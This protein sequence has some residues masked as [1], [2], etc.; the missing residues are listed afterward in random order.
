MNSL[1]YCTLWL[2]AVAVSLLTGCGPQ[3]GASAQVAI[4]DL[5]IV[6]RETGQDVVIRQRA[7]EGINE[8]TNQLQQL[9]ASL[10][11][12][13]ADEREKA[14]AAPSAEDAARLQQLT[15]QAR[16]QVGQAQQQAQQQANDLEAELIEDFRQ[17]LLPLAKQIAAE[18]GLSLILSK[19]VF[20]FW[21]DEAVD[22]TDAVV[23]AWQAQTPAPA[24]AEPA[25]A[26]SPEPAPAPEPAAN[27]A[28]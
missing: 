20:V 25:A 21:V 1:R 23:A 12:Q 14:G 17:D 13:L 28:E 6:A 11:Q 24:T 19:D 3:Q 4:I 27:P 2:A 5:S 22:I 26:V 9:A 10:D 18:R 15:A 7:E 16:Q 8:L